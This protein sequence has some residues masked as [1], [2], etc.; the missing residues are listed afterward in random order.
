MKTDYKN[1]SESQVKALLIVASESGSQSPLPSV[2]NLPNVERLLTDMSRT[3]DDSHANVLET[4]TKPTTSVQELTRIKGLAKAL[5]T[6]ADD[7]Q[8]LEAARLLYHVSVAAAFV[9][10]DAAISGRP[11]HKQR[12][13]YERLAETWSGHP[14]G[15]LFREAAARVAR[16]R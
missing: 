7:S 10:H 14:I 15:Q 12:F 5:M 2:A 8:H 1:L 13:Q 9:H 6:A 16:D 4:A 3:P 11:M